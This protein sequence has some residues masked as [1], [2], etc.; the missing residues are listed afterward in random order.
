MLVRTVGYAYDE[1]DRLVRV[2]GGDAGH[3]TF[4]RNAVGQL[5]AER[6]QGLNLRRETRFSADGEVQRR[7]VRGDGGTI[8]DIAYG[9]DA[10]GNLIER[11]DANLGVDMFAYDRVRR[12]TRHLDPLGRVQR[13]FTRLADGAVGILAFLPEAERATVP[14]TWFCEKNLD[15]GALHFDRLGNLVHRIIDGRE[16]TFAWDALGRLL[17]SRSD[18]G[19]IT[20]TATTRSAG[21]SPNVLGN[22]ALG[23]VGTPTACCARRRRPAPAGPR[24]A[25]GFMVRTCSSR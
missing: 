14:P 6:L 24:S 10:A 13:Y 8:F 11:R 4:E 15:T 12:L 3:I 5:V 7:R 20:Q 19:E 1:L 25:N 9:H 2:V 16:T 21:G 22:V 18:E 23:L 17:E